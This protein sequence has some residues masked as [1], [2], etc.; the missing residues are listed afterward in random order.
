MYIVS[1]SKLGIDYLNLVCTMLPPG[2]FISSKSFQIQVCAKVDS[3]P[4]SYLFVM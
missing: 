1:H 2:A 3:T 4:E